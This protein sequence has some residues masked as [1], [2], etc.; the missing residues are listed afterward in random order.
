[1]I[2][3]FVKLQLQSSNPTEIAQL[4]SRLGSARVGVGASDSFFVRF[5]LVYLASFN[6]LFA[7][8]RVHVLS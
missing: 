4:S 8:A 2:A 3:F 7:C 5:V 1:M 6:R